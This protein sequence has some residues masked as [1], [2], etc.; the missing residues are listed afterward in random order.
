MAESERIVRYRAHYSLRFSMS[1]LRGIALIEQFSGKVNHASTSEGQ[2]TELDVE[3]E[4][5]R[6]KDV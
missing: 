1:T 4:E 5:Q 2:W 6:V 3:L